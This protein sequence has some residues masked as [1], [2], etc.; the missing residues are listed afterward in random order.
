MTNTFTETAESYKE[1]LEKKKDIQPELRKH[2]EKLIKVNELLA[3]LDEAELN[4]IF[5]SQIFNDTARSYFKLALEKSKINTDTI[6]DVLSEIN[7]LFD[8]MD[9]ATAKKQAWE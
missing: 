9:A 8:T 3:D 2:L 7:Y 4:M 5:D 1:Y 6:Q